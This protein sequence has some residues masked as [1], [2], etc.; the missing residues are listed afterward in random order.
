MKR[1][2]K[3]FL[4]LLISLFLFTACN[5]SSNDSTCDNCGKEIEEDVKFCP[6]CGD[7]VEDDVVNNN[8]DNSNNTENNGENDVLY[9][10]S[11]NYVI[12]CL[13]KV[14][15]ILEI[16]AV[17]EDNDP[18][19]NLNKQGGYTSLVYFSYSLVDQA[20]VIGDDLIDKGTDAGGSVEV[21]TTVEYANRRNEY[22]S[23]FDGGA[24]TS[25]SHIVVGTMVVRTSDELKASQ[26]KLL[27][28]NVIY[29]LK[30]ELGKIVPP[31]SNNNNN[32]NS[33]TM[34][35]AL[36]SAET[37]AVEFETE[38][39]DDSL[40][41]N[42]LNEHLQ[43]ELGYSETE[44]NY[45]VE[46]ANINWLNHANK[47][48]SVYLN[49]VEEFG[50]PASWTSAFDIEGM[51]L[52]DGFSYVTVE[53]VMATIDWTAQLKK[54]VKHLSDFYDTFNRLDARG[55][56]ADIVANDDGIDYLL[57]NSGVDWKIHALNMANELWSQYIA[58]EYYQGKTVAYIQA[59]I[60]DELLNV[61][62]Y[63]ESE[64]DYAMEN[65][66]L[67]GI[68]Y[69]VDS[70]GLAFT[71]N[72]DGKSYSVSGIGM[73]VDTDI[74]I[75]SI[76]NGLP[77]T[78]IDSEAFDGCSEITSVIIPDSV[79]Y[80]GDDA[81]SL[82]YYLMSVS[83]S[84]SV[85]AIGEGS[86]GFCSNLANITVDEDNKY[87]KSIDGSLYSK[88]G[89]VL[90]QYAIGKTDVSFIV[91][92]GVISIGEEA[93]ISCDN[94]KSVTIPDSVTSIVKFAFYGCRSLISITIPDS[95]TSIGWAAF[96]ECTS[97]TSVVFENTVG[98]R[99]A[100]S[101]SATRW[102][103]FSSISLANPATAATFLTSTYQHRYWKRT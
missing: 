84:K 72:T 91:P 25:G 26:Q 21:Y 86:F 11:E 27:E 94:L 20:E 89:T 17:T 3:L 35:A 101:L 61:W 4:V 16:A 87:Y 85:T 33:N 46:N 100:S 29:A 34:N 14:P 81:F 32:N 54:Y 48:V 37:F 83:I 78:S 41:P 99:C 45:A 44:A 64:I 66:S 40:T 76:Y 96:S 98:W 103:S 1:R 19:G 67:E 7:K 31:S 69:P 15:G 55:Y 71:L 102:S 49:Y 88:D 9:A 13:E 2:V 43:D 56:L 12:A 8:T 18:N 38:Y 30:G 6:Y 5:N 47:Y 42:Y 95:V 97:L 28:S 60:V 82:C 90:I 77:V 62:K 58:E 79:I 10:P 74:V 92:D 23:A 50:E 80:I 65:M 57:E 36:S 70:E 51:L 59:D 22:L 75:P 68:V 73:C 52:E 39:P 93:F 53:A 63:T 24:L